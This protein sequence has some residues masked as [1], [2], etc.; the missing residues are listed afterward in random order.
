MKLKVTPEDFRVEE[1]TDFAVSQEPGEYAV[2]RLMKSSWDTFDLV[3][4]LSR[5]MGVSRRAISLGGIKD[6]YGRTAQIVTVRNPPRRPRSLTDKNFT[7]EFSGYSEAPLSARAVRGNRFS[8]VIRDMS[9][10]EVRAALDNLRVVRRSGIPNY[11]DEQRF[12]SA[13]HGAGFMGKAVFLGKREEA[14]KLFFLPSKHDDQKT[15]KLKKLV[16]SRWG[17]WAECMPA[18]F[19]EYRRV[20]SRLVESPR[21]YHKALGC[22]DRR[23]LVF[24]LNA[25]QSFLFNGILA[26]YMECLAGK[27]GFRIHRV[28]YSR[29]TFVFPEE[30]PEDLPPALLR[31]SLPVPGN[32]SAITDPDVGAILAR[33]LDAEGISLSDLR[34]RQMSGIRVHGVERTA[35]AAVEE[36]STPEI[37]G[38]ELYPGKRK[39][40]LS[41]FL[42]RGSYATILMK[43]IAIQDAGRGNEASTPEAP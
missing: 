34:V 30:L 15:R 18:A 22:L 35:Y 38:D 26:G 37:C 10:A 28:P 1:V 19:G 24:I 36:L 32:D 12:G 8:V 4:L 2:Y 9:D 42:P 43:R 17:R 11:Y 27:R 7:A 3:D 13:R 33:V 5:R 21:A 39:A 29:G 23:F 25:Y 41:F 6:R 14:L 31:K 20:L 16:T 40:S